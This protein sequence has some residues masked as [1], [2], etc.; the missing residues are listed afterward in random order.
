MSYKP[1]YA[2]AHLAGGVTR[3]LLGDFERG[4]AGYEW[5]TEC[6]TDIQRWSFR[7]RRWD[8]SP[9]N[10]QPILLHVEQGLGDTLQFIRYVPLVQER[11]G[12]VTVCCPRE[13]VPVLARCRG[14][15]QLLTE[16]PWDWTGTHASLLSLPGIFGTTLQTI[17]VQV[18]YLSADAQRV[19]RWRQELSAQ[20][21][22]DRSG[23]STNVGIA[24]QGNPKHK[25][26][27][28]R[29]VP[30]RGSS[31]WRGCRGCDCSAFRWDRAWN[32]CVIWATVFR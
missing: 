23:Q 8:G 9:L 27:R 16:V 1:D 15:D 21:K 19:E 2:D 12:K 31:G 30:R 7:Q 4:W 32:N 5:R 10:G 29:S 20:G 17:P 3:L 22:K 24:W 11:G 26:D 28:Q 6:Q 13:V 14:I 18:P 25:H